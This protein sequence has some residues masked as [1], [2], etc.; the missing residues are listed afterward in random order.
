LPLGISPSK[1]KIGEKR[2][3]QIT[4]WE[5][6]SMITFRTGAWAQPHDGVIVDEDATITLL[7]APNGYFDKYEATPARGRSTWGAP[8]RWGH[9]RKAFELGEVIRP[10]CIYFPEHFCYCFSSNLCVLNTTNMDSRCF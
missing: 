2:K 6:E 4:V 3:G 8:H 9:A 7:Q 1:L 10:K 5:M